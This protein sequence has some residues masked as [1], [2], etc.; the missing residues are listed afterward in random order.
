MAWVGFNWLKKA[1]EGVVKIAAAPFVKA[2]ELLTGGDKDND[3]NPVANGKGPDPLP[4]PPSP[5][6]VDD[7]PEAKAKAEETAANM[8]RAS[9]A[10][11]KIRGRAA[12]ILTSPSGLMSTPSLSRR[13]LLGG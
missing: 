10:E 5:K 12:T 4:P 9:A 7:S 13:T 11:R 6:P 1:A 8:E 3:S 2:A